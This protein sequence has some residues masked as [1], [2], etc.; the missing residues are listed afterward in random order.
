MEHS[1]VADI[2]TTLG[3]LVV[4]GVPAVIGG[5]IVYALFGESY[6]AVTIYEMLLLMTAGAFIAR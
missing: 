4:C 2:S 1:K 3:R 5:G 6:T